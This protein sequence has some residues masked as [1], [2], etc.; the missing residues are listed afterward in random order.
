MAE[1]KRN[2]QEIKTT[3]P[4]VSVIVPIYKAEKYL[5][6]CIDSLLAQTLTDFEILL[7]DDGS[8]D[9][10]GEICDLYAK[11]DQR[12]RVFHK[13]NGGV[14]SA[15]QC[16]LENARGI[17]TIHVDPDDW[18]ENDMLEQMV[19]KAVETDADI[20]ICDFFVDRGKNTILS[21]QNPKSLEP[22]EVLKKLFIDMTGSCCNKL[23]RKSCYF[24]N[25]I[26][27]PIGINF[28]EDMIVNILLL[29][30]NPRII[31]LHRAFY[32]YVQGIN[33]NSMVKIIGIKAIEQTM[34]LKSYI[35]DILPQNE[36]IRFLANIRLNHSI[37]KK[38]FLSN[39]YSS[40]EFKNKFG[41]FKKKL[42]LNQRK[43]FAPW[44]ER[45]FLY[46][47]CIGLYRPALCVWYVL[48]NIRKRILYFS[49]S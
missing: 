33:E 3:I 24:E 36:E 46:L 42:I 2:N 12:I 19:S 43:S 20:V 26:N 44:I 47:S 28:G 40:R 48:M 27:F 5:N 21:I 39:L 10:S 13:K 11:T 25:K 35:L 14:S 1:V 7:I 41:N 34:E 4:L 16:G 29:L 17:Y 38:A 30:T 32:H 8:P 9:E 49:F 37:L 6:K 18:V 31:Y 22:D 45:F 23:I 15:R